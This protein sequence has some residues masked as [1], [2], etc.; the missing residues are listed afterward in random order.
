MSVRI[1]EREHLRRNIGLS[2]QYE[3]V[4]VVHKK[5]SFSFISL[6]NLIFFCFL[7]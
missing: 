5:I 1:I 7:V 4:D 3:E 6:K 2:S